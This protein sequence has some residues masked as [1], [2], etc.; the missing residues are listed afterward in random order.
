MPADRSDSELA[1]M[2]AELA[3][4]APADRDAILDQLDEHLGA[5][6]WKLLSAHAISQPAQDRDDGLS[7]W[8]AEKA[9]TGQDMTKLAQEALIAC[10]RDL[11][12]SHMS[13]QLKQAGPSLFTRIGS[14]L[15][16]DGRPS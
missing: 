12:G 4:L 5:R 14:S 16:Q 9:T 2:I 15:R 7:K 8:L 13:R 10:I 11:R 3:R 6:A 1:E